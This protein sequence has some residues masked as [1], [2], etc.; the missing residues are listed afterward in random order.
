[1]KILV[2]DD[3]VAFAQG[4]ALTLKVHPQNVFHLAH[5]FQEASR[6]IDEIKPDIVL[7]DFKLSDGNGHDVLRKA[8]G[9]SRSSKVILITAFAEKEMAIQ[10][11][12]LKVDYLMEKPFA[13]SDLEAV[14]KGL[15]SE[16]EF[17]IN[18][19]DL[20]VS[21]ADGQSARLTLKEFLIFK[22]FL[23]HMDQRIPREKI[24]AQIWPQETIS[25]N[26]FDTHIYNLK[27]KLPFFKERL[28]V[29]R[30]LGYC[31]QSRAASL[32]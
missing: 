16:E 4:L 20:V 7:T 27:M 3:D 29:V 14:M 22:F 21:W 19:R 28:N 23:G 2:V 24:I 17:T 13:T 6:K 10:S 5:S 31:Y 32:N 25:S 15:F 12:N 30:G 8:R 26:V 18:D 1:M 9:V 11:A